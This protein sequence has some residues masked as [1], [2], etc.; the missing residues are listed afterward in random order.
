MTINNEGLKDSMKISRMLEGI[1]EP[2][3]AMA[4]SVVLTQVKSTTT[5]EEVVTLLKTMAAVTMP[6]SQGNQRQ[7]SGLDKDSS[8]KGGGKPHPSQEKGSIKDS[9]VHPGTYS[10]S[11]WS[12]LTV[13]QQQKVREERKKLSEKKRKTRAREEASTE[14]KNDS[15]KDS[16]DAA[17]QD[18]GSQFGRDGSKGKK[19]K[20]G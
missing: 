8:K 20:S 11:D 14:K 10:N 3:L 4:K 9:D 18:A 6:A 13:K 1:T 17:T 7:V 5:F 2:S 19:S 15:S 12:K 16:D